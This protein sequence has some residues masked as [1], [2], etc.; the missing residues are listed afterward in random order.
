MAQAFVQAV[1]A[2]VTS[3]ATSCTTTGI[4]TTSGDLIVLLGFESSGVTFAATPLSD[5]KSNTW[6]AGIATFGTTNKQIEKFDANGT[7]GASHT[8]TCTTTTSAFPAVAAVEFSGMD[9]TTSCID[10]TATTADASST[11]PHTSAATATTTQADEAVVCASNTSA[12]TATYVDNV[13][14]LCTSQNNTAGTPLGVGYRLVTATGTYSA[15]FNITAG[16]VV[17]S[18]S[19]ST[20]KEAAPGG[21][22][23]GLGPALLM[24]PDMTM[25]VGW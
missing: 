16:T 18:Q 12:G 15:S 13:G 22:P 14:T 6:T 24:Q 11:N 17:A 4:T 2:Q 21:A 10:K 19:T 20:W 3:A 23:P 8:F 9:L 7:R 25:P 1:S 5:S